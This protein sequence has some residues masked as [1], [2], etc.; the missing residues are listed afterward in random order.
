MRKT[1]EM[2]RICIG[3]NP[4]PTQEELMQVAVD[5]QEMSEELG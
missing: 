4:N 1:E 5:L 2:P 3:D